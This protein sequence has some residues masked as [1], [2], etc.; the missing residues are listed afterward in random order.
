MFRRLISK[1]RANRG[2][3]L[4]LLGLFVLRGAIADWNPIPS[5]S[6]RPTV[7]EGDVVLVDKTAYDWQ[8]PFTHIALRRQGEPQRGDIVVFYSPTDGTRLI[9]RVVGLPGDTVAVHGGALWLNGQAVPLTAHRHSEESTAW[10][11]L[12]ALKAVE[13]LPGNGAHAVH[14]V[15]ALPALPARRDVPPLTLGQDQYYMLGDNRDNS[16]DSRYIGPVPRR[17]LVGRVSR[18]VASADIDGWWTPRWSR[19]GMALR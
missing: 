1:L 10:G 12:D 17:L 4:F 8:L 19:W 6:M 3:L 16:A 9:K 5:G 15:Q 18:L 13:H 7:L 11:P 14:E 2:F